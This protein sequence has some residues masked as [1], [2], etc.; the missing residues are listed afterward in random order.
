M[1]YAALTSGTKNSLDLNYD[2]LFKHIPFNSSH[3]SGLSE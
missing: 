1:F 2:L 3:G